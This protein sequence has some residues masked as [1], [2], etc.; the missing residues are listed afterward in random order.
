LAMAFVVGHSVIRDRQ[1]GHLWWL[2]PLRDCIA[3][4][5]WASAFAGRT[6]YWRGDKFVL[7]NGRLQRPAGDPSQAVAAEMSTPRS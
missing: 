2:I 4:L 5:I 1:V 7:K 6:V 3:L